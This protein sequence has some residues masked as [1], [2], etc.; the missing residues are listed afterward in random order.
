MFYTSSHYLLT[1]LQRAQA[2]HSH[3]SISTLITLLYIFRIFVR[4]SSDPFPLLYK[5]STSQFC[6]WIKYC[7]STLVLMKVDPH[8]RIPTCLSTFICYCFSSL[9]LS[10]HSRQTKLL[11]S[12]TASFRLPPLLKLIIPPSYSSHIHPCQAKTQSKAPQT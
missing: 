4:C 7:H 5:N 2:I 1:L 3:S 10:F 11:I 12:Q 9:Y 8:D 6:Y